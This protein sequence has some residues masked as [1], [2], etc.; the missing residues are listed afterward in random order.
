MPVPWKSRLRDLLLAGGAV[1]ALGAAG[2]SSDDDGGGVPCGNANPDPCICGRP[3]A[4]Q[5]GNLACNLEKTCQQKGGTYFPGTTEQ[6][7]GATV[8]NACV[9]PDAGADGGSTGG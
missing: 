2:C 4:S 6:A 8:T 3:E 7:D 1:A 9:F 5:E